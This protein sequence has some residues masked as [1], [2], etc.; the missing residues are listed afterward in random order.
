MR[1]E[2]NKFDWLQVISI[3][4]HQN[5]ADLYMSY[6]CS[7][8]SNCRPPCVETT[9]HLVNKISMPSNCYQMYLLHSLDSF[10]IQLN[11]L[12][13]VPNRDAWDRIVIKVIIMAARF[14]LKLIRCFFSGLTCPLYIYFD[15]LPWFLSFYNA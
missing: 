1:I 8:P 15:F 6:S 7:I 11:L 12:P 10:Y 2:N 4:L 5:M 13:S 3:I 9:S 14:G